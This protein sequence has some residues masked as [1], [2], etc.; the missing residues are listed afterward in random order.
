MNFCSCTLNKTYSHDHQNKY[1]HIIKMRI[2]IP[3]IVWYFI[4]CALASA[5]PFDNVGSGRAIQ[6]DGVNDYINIGDE[7]DDLNLPLTISVWVNV[8]SDMTYAFPI[9]NSQD[10]TPLYNGFT[11]A[12]SPTAFSIQYGDGGGE[13]NPAFRRGK[14]ASIPNIAGRWVN[15]TAVMR[16]HS[17]MDLYLNGVN[18]GG[19]YSGTSNLPMSSLFPADD[20]KIGYWFSNGITTYFKGAMDE[21]RIFNRS[22]SESDIR[23]QMCRR[24]TGDEVGL[25]GYWS[26]DEITGNVLKDKSA[27]NFDGQVFGDAVRVYSGAPIGDE[28]VYLYS[29]VMANKTLEFDGVVVSNIQGSPEGIHVY[30]VMD[31]PSQATGLNP[32]D[33]NKPYF[34]IFIASSDVGNTFGLN[35]SCKTF[36]RDNNSISI[37]TELLS[38]TSLIDHKE[39]VWEQDIVIAEINLGADKIICDQSEFVIDS[40]AEESTSSIL[41]N[42]GQTTETIT[43]S[44]SGFYSVQ[45]FSSC[46]VQKD[47]IELTFLNS[48]PSFSL[49]E[50]EELCLIKTK[51]LKP[52]NSDISGEYEFIWQDGSTSDSLIV[53]AFGIYWV[54]VKNVCGFENDSITLTQRKREFMLPN[55]ITPNGDSLNQYFVVDESIESPNKLYIYNRWGDRVFSSDRYENNWDAQGL[56]TGVYYYHLQGGCIGIKKGA[57]TIFR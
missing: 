47:T 57:I 11:F 26:F 56:S 51:L 13:D 29:S 18:I 20:A 39:I 14:S 37:W 12:V 3:S 2:L 52:Y 10:N 33:A 21:L 24:L 44:E 16:G 7:Y 36:N 30:K 22:L 49:G 1:L 23:H 42:N 19:Q 9:F 15:L 35:P 50:N 38:F 17:D 48:P 28:S 4:S 45:V 27:N 53:T 34:G 8:S 46:S 32:S 6:F 25:I 31:S 40:G 41:W 55:V 43:V 5:Q 54:T